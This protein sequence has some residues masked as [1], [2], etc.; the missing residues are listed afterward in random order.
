MK[1]VWKGFQEEVIPAPGVDSSRSMRKGHQRVWEVTAGSM[2]R[3][4]KGK[5]R[6]WQEVEL[7]SHQ[8]SVY[9]GP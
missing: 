7:Q 6:K 2:W 9:I 8:G 4:L 5:G 3:R 1:A